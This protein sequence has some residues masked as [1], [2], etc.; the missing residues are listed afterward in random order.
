MIHALSLLILSMA[1]TLAPTAASSAAILAVLPGTSIGSALAAGHSDL[2]PSRAIKHGH[3]RL[4]DAYPHHAIVDDLAQILTE[5]ARRGDVETLAWCMARVPHETRRAWAKDDRL[6]QLVRA[7][8]VPALA[9]YAEHVI[10][11]G[12]AMYGDRRTFLSMVESL[13]MDLG[14]IDVLEWLVTA[15]PTYTLAGHLADAAMHG[16]VRVLEWWFA[17]YPANPATGDPWSVLLVKCF[18]AATYSGQVSVLEYCRTRDRDMFSHLDDPEIVIDAV[19][20]SGRLDAVE[21]WWAFF[22][23]N[24]TSSSMPQCFGTERGI[25]RHS[26]RMPVAVLDWLWDKT[27]VTNE[28]QCRSNHY[29]GGAVPLA[30]ATSMIPDWFSS[31]TIVAELDWWHAKSTEHGWAMPWQESLVWNLVRY[32]HLE[33]LDWAAAHLS[34]DMFTRRSEE[35]AMELFTQPD[36]RLLDWF[37]DHRDFAPM[38]KPA[39][40]CSCLIQSVATCGIRHM[41]WWHQR[42]GLTEQEVAVVRESSKANPTSI[43][44]WWTRSRFDGSDMLPADRFVD[45]D[46]LLATSPNDVVPRVQTFMYWSDLCDRHRVPFPATGDQLF[47]VALS[48]SLGAPL[49]ILDWC[50]AYFA[51]PAAELAE[52]TPSLML[53]ALKRKQWAALAWWTRVLTAYRLPIILPIAEHR[54]AS[55][56]LAEWRSEM[57]HPIEIQCDADDSEADYSDEE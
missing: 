48:S 16:Q 30:W 6:S 14:N 2:A 34:P 45:Y 7:G 10:A 51:P 29:R 20:S 21:W 13:A 52:V 23:E 11:T 57:L 49:S 32:G 47:A 36:S 28:L 19:F 5:A 33:S 9:W 44:S 4:L 1:A 31:S 53:D 35:V 43:V 12:A 42:I 46:M 27:A 37:W 54:V 40:M 18:R 41:A 56:D 38:P 8:S 55:S 39:D 15:D 17:R 3:I 22:C 25:A 24:N 50:L 26:T